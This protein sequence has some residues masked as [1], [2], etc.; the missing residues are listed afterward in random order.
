[1]SRL[2]ALAN[3]LTKYVKVEHENE[4]LEFSLKPYQGKNLVDVKQQLEDS[5]LRPATF[6]E[7]FALV[8]SVITKKCKFPGDKEEP[9][10]I[11]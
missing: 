5:G 6:A 10:Q 2:H 7:I 3:S 1:M 11:Y 4:N 8:N 9:Q